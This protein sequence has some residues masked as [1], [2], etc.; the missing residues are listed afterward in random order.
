MRMNLCRAYEGRTGGRDIR[1][2]PPVK[3]TDRRDEYWRELGGEKL[4]MLR[5]SPRAW[6]SR[7][8]CAVA[9]TDSVCVNFV[10]N[11]YQ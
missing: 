6:S 5:A 10:P 8:T 4:N 2:R 9:K 3:Q 7:D 1:R 11:V